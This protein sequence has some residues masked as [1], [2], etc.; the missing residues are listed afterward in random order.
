MTYKTENL[1]DKYKDLLPIDN[2]DY[3][4]AK[5][6]YEKYLQI[7]D[8]I[9]DCNDEESLNDLK[10]KI[11]N[12]NPWENALN[13]SN[14]FRSIADSDLSILEPLIQE[15]INNFK[16]NIFSEKMRESFSDEVS[17]I[18]SQYGGEEEFNT[19]IKENLAKPFFKQIFSDFEHAFDGNFENPRVIILGINPR[20]KNLKHESYE[21]TKVYEK[22]FDSKRPTLYS[23][24]D[25][26]SKDE[27]YFIPNG[28]FFMKN[29]KYTTPNK[30]KED[31]LHQIT[32][33]EKNTPYALWEFFPYATNSEIEWYDGIKLSKDITKYLELK[34][35]LPS[36]IWLLCLLTYTLKKAIFSRRE[37]YLFLTK[38]NESFKNIFFENYRKLLKINNNSKVKIL[39]KNNNQ[40]RK[41]HCNNIKEY[42]KEKMN[43]A[44]V[45]DFFEKIWG[46][47]EKKKS[48]NKKVNSQRIVKSRKV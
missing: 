46:I 13:D 2:Q 7:F 22:P 25:V 17:T 12:N 18:Y 27:Y 32:S 21:L 20:L 10:E 40:N 45:E 34:K 42:K 3:K 23:E 39:T 48:P 24:K 8:G 33:R 28:F 43:F 31:F 35:I 38:T 36:Q 41:F 30:I 15:E 9:I 1:K 16:D 14:Q 19:A 11:E 44:S 4:D 47:P 37:M 26:R 29:K 5:D 6:Y